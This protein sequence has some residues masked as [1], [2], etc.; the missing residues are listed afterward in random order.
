MN[1]VKALKC[2]MIGTPDAT[3]QHVG[4]CSQSM[5][6]RFKNGNGTNFV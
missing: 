4:Q 3:I 1:S 2:E 6:P 5:L